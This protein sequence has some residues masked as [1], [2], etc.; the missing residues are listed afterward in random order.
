MS[1]EFPGSCD[2]GDFHPRHLGEGGDYCAG[3]A[4]PG[5]E[6]RYGAAALEPAERKRRGTDTFFRVQLRPRP[7]VS[8]SGPW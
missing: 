4:E 2:L 1:Y 3:Y 6:S 5:S 7:G 8:N